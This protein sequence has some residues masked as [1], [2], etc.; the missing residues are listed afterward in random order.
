MLPIGGVRA[1]ATYEED[2]HI[3]AF[4]DGYAEHDWI[5]TGTEVAQLG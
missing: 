3:V 1:L 4:G 2:A 5:V